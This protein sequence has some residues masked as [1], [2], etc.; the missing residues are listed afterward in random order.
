MLESY[1]IAS[2]NPGENCVADGR[3]FI[4]NQEEE[5]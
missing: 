1:F 2:R 4:S 3:Y 5:K